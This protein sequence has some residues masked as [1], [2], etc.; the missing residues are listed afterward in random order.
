LRNSLSRRPSPSNLPLALPN[1]LRLPRL[2]WERLSL[3]RTVSLRRMHGARRRSPP[4]PKLPF[5][6]PEGNP[7]TS[8][9]SRTDRNNSS[10]LK[11]GG[12][13]FLVG[14]RANTA[15]AFMERSTVEPSMTTLSRDSSDRC[16][17]SSELAK[18][19][20]S[21][22]STRNM[23]LLIQDWLLAG[24]SGVWLARNLCR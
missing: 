5:P 16:I 15:H 23:L 9:P 3:L 17:A 11:T 14:I 4:S 13:G 24:P 22:C 7:L 12:A 1:S 2:P 8:I 6:V 21:T 10:R 19:E 18:S 20:A